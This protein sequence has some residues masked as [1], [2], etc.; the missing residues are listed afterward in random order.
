[1]RRSVLCAL[2]AIA[3]GGRERSTGPETP[4][5]P[6]APA[7]ARPAAAE[8]PVL[9]DAV[10][11]A[12]R[13]HEILASVSVVPARSD[14][15]GNAAMAAAASA[16]GQP[17]EAVAWS[18]D[19]E[20]D[21][22]LLKTRVAG[23]LARA[24][25]PLPSALPLHL[26]RAMATAASNPHVFAL[27]AG[28]MGNMLALVSGQKAAGFGFDAHAA[29]GGWVVS[30]VFAGGPAAAAGVKRGDRVL[31][32]DGRAFD[33]QSLLAMLLT[34]PGEKA[35]VE[36]ER[37]GARRRVNLE[38][39]S[40]ARPIVDSRV[41]GRGLGYLHIRYLSRSKDPAGDAAVLVAGALKELDD[42]KV[43]RLVV[44]L[45]DD[46]GGSPF[47]VASI[48]VHGDPL[49]EVQT[50]GGAAEPMAR[51]AQSWK[52]R[53]RMA[54]LVNGQTYAAAEMVA[55]SLQGHGEARVFG[56]PTGGALTIPGQEQL[57]GGV[58]LFFPG[59]LVLDPRG[60]VPAGQRV[61]PDE[62]IPSSTAADLAAGVDRQLEAAVA[63]LKKR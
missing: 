33:E 18:G 30:D 10:A 52:K 41:L 22:A 2:L 47:D 23:V 53:H 16:I 13:A 39:Q 58:T 49:L 56:Q 62:E 50:P 51:T 31:A 7:P 25:T 17:P 5:A 26:A 57:P 37:G 32:L 55:L 54:V 20:R 14:V 61:A 3:C 40:V 60:V 8:D 19:S 63:W 45:R 35:A 59:Q 11:A 1:M 4:A 46:G 38:A 29:A 43:D 36:I 6:A 34:A 21:R 48:L 27:D 24:R 42:K 44:D 15:L 28:R 12:V 9:A